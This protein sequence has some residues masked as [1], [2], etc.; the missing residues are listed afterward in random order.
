M[1]YDIYSDI[2]GLINKNK[3][4][5]IYSEEDSL[6]ASFFDEFIGQNVEFDQFSENIMLSLGLIQNPPV[7]IKTTLANAK[8][9]LKLNVGNWKRECIVCVDKKIEI[10][11]SEKN[12]SDIA[13]VDCKIMNKTKFINFYSSLFG[14][15]FDDVKDV[16]WVENLYDLHYANKINLID[17]S[18]LKTLNT[19]EKKTF[20]SLNSKDLESRMRLWQNVDSPWSWIRFLQYHY[21][22]RGK[23]ALYAD[24]LHL[25]TW[26]R[27][28][29][30]NDEVFIWMCRQLMEREE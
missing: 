14:Y 9:I 7:K 25:E 29:T 15:K 28:T 22:M 1:I 2:F 12:Y 13:V 10:K 20:S 18:L 11:K 6:S 19:E 21:R 8:K 5:F 17:K 27:E 4:I 30:P 23:S 3:L 16:L 24:A 26:A